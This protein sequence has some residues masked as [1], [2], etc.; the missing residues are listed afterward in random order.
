MTW[1]KLFLGSL[2]VSL[3][4]VVTAASM[5]DGCNCF[6]VIAG[7]N[8][9]VDGSVMLAH[10]EDDSGEMMLNMYAV[11]RLNGNNAYLWGEFPG[12]NDC[13]HFLNEWG[14]AIASDGCPSREDCE[15][16]TDGGVLYEVRLTVAQRAHSAREAVKIIGHLV[17]TRGYQ[18]SGRTY[19]IADPHEGW[20][21]SVVK[22]RHWVAKRIADDEVMAL[23]NNYII[24]EVNLA[25]TLNCYGARDVETYARER[26]WYDPERDGHFSFKKA[27]C[28]PYYYTYEH[29]VIRQLCAQQYLTGRNDLVP[30][31]DTL[32]FA[33]RPNRKIGLADLMQIMQCH[34][35]NSEHKFMY[36]RE[37]QWNHPVGICTDVTV[38]S[39]I[40]QLRADRPREV[41]CVMWVCAGRPCTEPYIPWYLG[42]SRTP[43]C[44]RRYASAAQAVKDHFTAVEHK[45]DQWPHHIYWKGVD[46]WASYAT[47]WHNGIAAVQQARDKRQAKACKAFAKMD[48]KLQKYYDPRTLQVKDR[49]AMVE[50]INAFTEKLYR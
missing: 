19:V 21:C 6:C 1:V 7:R 22:G 17:E 8:T 20:I 31:P 16:V 42:I 18:A 45:R 15:D 23:P 36:K 47:D 48:K 5:P 38:L 14:V 25:D 37:R 12:T 50:S 34:G 11:P 41:G 44:W 29:N 3:S 10:N 39:A 13:D 33:V 4:L 35:E 2:A 28:D 27:Y 9:T 40:F 46:R 24:D 49:E 43:D 30:D 32:P 26:G